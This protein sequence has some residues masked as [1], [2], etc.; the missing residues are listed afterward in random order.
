[1]VSME[2]YIFDISEYW[3]QA[4]VTVEECLKYLEYRKQAFA[5]RFSLYIKL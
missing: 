5:F 3:K 4:V 1:M 2:P